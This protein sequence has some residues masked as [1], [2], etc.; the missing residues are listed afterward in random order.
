MEVPE[1]L[2]AVALGWA[3]AAAHTAA[4]RGICLRLGKTA[5]AGA[6]EGATSVFVPWFPPE[7]RA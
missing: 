4:L 7:A 2:H 6:R 1:L 3:L 5:I